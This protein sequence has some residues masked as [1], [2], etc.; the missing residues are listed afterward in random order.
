MT[1]SRDPVILSNPALLERVDK[2][3]DLNIGQHVPLPQLVVVGDQ[4]SGK[5]SLLESLSGIPFPRDQSLCTRHATQITSR[6]DSNDSVLINIIPGPNATEEH[7]EQLKGFRNKLPSGSEFRKQFTDIL[8]KANEKMG[9]R[10]DLSTGKGEVFSKDVLKI[11][12]SGPRED[13][14]TIID[15]PGI[16]RTTTQGTTRDDM[17][18][19]KDMVK[20]YIKDDRTII[21]AVLPSNVDIAT[22]EILELAK[23]V[24]KNGERTLG[25]L[26][27]PDLVLE[28]SAQAAVCDLVLNKKRSLTLGYFLVRNRGA[29]GGFEEQSELDR[30][31]QTQP[32]ADLPKDRVG[33][34]ALKEQLQSLLVDITRREF[35]KLLQDVNNQIKDCKRELDSLGLPRQDEREQRSFLSHIAG[36][37]QERAREALA[38]HYNADPVF[39]Q[40]EL[41][42]ITQVMNITDVFNADFRESAHSRHFEDLGVPKTPVVAEPKAEPK[43]EQN[44][45]PKAEPVAKRPERP[46]HRD[47][48]E[49]PAGVT[50]DNL[51]ALL[52]KAKVDEIAPQELS[53]LGDIIIPIQEIPKPRDNFTAWINDVHLQFRGMDLGTFNPYLVSISFAEQSHK[54]GD[55]TKIYMSRVIITLHRF[56]AAALRSVCTEEQAR[57]HLWYAILDTLVERYKTAMAKANLL[58]EVEQRKQPYTLNRQFAAARMEAR[59]HRITEL[60]RPTARRDTKQFGGVQ[61]MVSLDDIA[62]AAAGKPNVEQLQEDIHDILKAYYGLAADRFIDN[63]F[64]LAVDYYLLTGPSSPLKVFTQDWVIN[65]EPGELE[66][67]ASETKQAKKNRSRLGKK[68]EDLSNALKILKSQDEQ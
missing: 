19:V 11:E 17:T 8:K 42:L 13:Y 9:L 28:P 3:R 44:A 57:N 32:W 68:I 67:I 48:E 60:L 36:A 21:L 38:A 1:I 24:D 31:F 58:I 4:S 54:W 20:G 49:T 12:I 53:E 64:Q 50:V 62:K 35:P 47:W 22:Q 55:I 5:S 43:A 63:V 18:L 39:E 30:V 33:I 29:D 2:L 7:K 52:D 51:R 6:R 23:D 26:T 15:V 16:F 10:T 34:S 65:L 45:D 56:I 46:A 40:D 61:Y 66:R 37:F 41:R 27:K 25:V 14:L 59:G